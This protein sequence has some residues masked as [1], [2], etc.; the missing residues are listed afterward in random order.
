MRAMTM[1][2]GRLELRDVAEPE[3]GPGQLLVEPLSAGVCG[4]DLS[5]LEHTDDFV[6]SS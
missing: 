5:A 6:E 3:P 4:G 2:N 1:F